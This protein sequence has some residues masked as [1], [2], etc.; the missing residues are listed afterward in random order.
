MD[1]TLEA[2]TQQVDATSASILNTLHRLQNPSTITA[3]NEANIDND[4]DEIDE[5]IGDK[6]T[7][8]AQ[9]QFTPGVRI[10][11]MVQLTG[12]DYK[13]SIKAPNTVAPLITK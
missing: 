3:A 12:G 8:A 2:L 5:Q 1:G 9:P 13:L 7:E 10:Q 11:Q 6:F 4:A